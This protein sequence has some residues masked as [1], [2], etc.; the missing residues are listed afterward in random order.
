MIIITLF[1]VK[2][3]RRFVG[4]NPGFVVQLKLFAKMDYTLD[5]SNEKFKLYRLKIAADKFKK[6][7]IL[8]V[9]QTDLVKS[10]PALIRELPEPVVYRCRKCRRVVASKSNLITHKPKNNSLSSPAKEA[11]ADLSIAQPYTEP[12]TSDQMTYLTERLRKN[13]L[14]SDHSRSSDKQDTNICTKT[15]FIEP[16][17][18]M[19]DIYNKAEGRLYCP[20]CA[21][22]L[23]SFN[24]IMGKILMLNLIEFKNLI[25]IFF[26][27]FT[28][29]KCPCGA[30]IQPAFYLLPSRVD[31]SNVVQNVQITV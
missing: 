30:E 13:S 5:R 3:K 18:W 8:S 10:D 24:W 6:V 1:R 21:S 12:S 16:L 26:F 11:A 2:S 25:T 22:K 29:T 23:G 9:S 28:A 31:Y 7:K 14:G 4:P 27:K 17:A 19:G 15:F 20:K